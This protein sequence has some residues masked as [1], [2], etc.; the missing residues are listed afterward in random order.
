MARVRVEME[1]VPDTS[2]RVETEAPTEKA[3]SA[4]HVLARARE[5]GPL[6]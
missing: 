3:L 6:E 1:A 5:A 2:R 4:V